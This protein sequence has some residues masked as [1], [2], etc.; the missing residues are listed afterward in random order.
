MHAMA[1]EMRIDVKPHIRDDVPKTHL[2]RTL[3]IIANWLSLK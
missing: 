3:S 1:N 2:R